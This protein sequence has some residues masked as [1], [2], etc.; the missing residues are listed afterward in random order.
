MN[1]ESRISIPGLTLEAVLP[2]HSA[3]SGVIRAVT[4]D[5][6]AWTAPSSATEGTPV[7]IANGETKILADGATAAL[8]IVVKRTAA[9][10][11]DGSALIIISA[12]VA[13]ADMLAAVETAILQTLEAQAAGH[14]D[15][16]IRRAELDSLRKFR[17]QLKDEVAAEDVATSGGRLAS[18]DMTG[19]F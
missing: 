3:G 7:A 14:G 10:D 1:F 2:G 5:T 6:V 15:Q 9:A 16:N 8:R 18:C 12:G 17:D 4:A 11:L 13:P 19:L